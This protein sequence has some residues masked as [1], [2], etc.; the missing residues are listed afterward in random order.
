MKKII[1]LI[2][3]GKLKEAFQQVQLY[4]KQYPTDPQ[5]IILVA[6]I[7][8]AAG[9]IK[10]A[11]FT[12]EHAV[13]QDKAY[14]AA[15]SDLLAFLTHLYVSHY[16][17]DKVLETVD[18]IE[19]QRITLPS[20]Y[21]YLANALAKSEQHRQSFKFY[22]L[23]LTF[24]PDDLELLEGAS[25][26]GM[27]TGDF[28]KAELYLRKAI[29]I[30]PNNGRYVWLFSDIAKNFDTVRVKELYIQFLE[31]FEQSPSAIENAVYWHYGLGNLALNIQKYNESAEHYMTGAKVR[32]SEFKYYSTDDEV[33]WLKQ[34]NQFQSQLP[35]LTTN[36]DNKSVVPIFIVGMPRSGT[37][38]LATLLSKYEKIKDLGELPIM[39]NLAQQLSSNSI[40]IEQV[41]NIY[42][43]EVNK[44]ADNHLYVIDQLPTNFI[45]INLI[46]AA[47]P[48]AK[49]ILL[50]RDMNDI[51]ISN[52]FFLFAPNSMQFTYNETDLLKFIQQFKH[53]TKDVKLTLHY[54]DLVHETESTINQLISKGD[55]K[56]GE[57]V[58]KTSYVATGSSVEV[59]KDIYTSSVNKW[60]KFESYFPGLFPI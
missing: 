39:H 52:L 19:A 14:S 51:F 2:D 24:Y 16:N 7:Q 44:R 37:T 42:L 56:T 34:V 43:A 55:I 30:Q 4:I 48:E 8:V 11:I 53:M 40:T 6:K 15:K 22:E 21:N 23:G 13:N 36:T 10:K 58:D 32:R 5:G 49:I 9:L 1:E 18:K 25:N 12:I 35:L 47:L 27:I 54:E 41:R 46:R 17:F 50:E 26:L 59:R 28:T 45:N 3:K 29:S 31:H 57:K 60:K 33:S 38:L 20:S